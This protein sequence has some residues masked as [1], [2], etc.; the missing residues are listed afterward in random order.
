MPPPICHP[1][2][3]PIPS[4][5]AVFSAVPFGPRAGEYL[6]WYYYG[7][8]KKL[9]KDIYA[10]HNIHSIMCGVGLVTPGGIIGVNRP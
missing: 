3:G 5:L 7:G 2:N 8:G 4:A 1:A 9:M 10:K 6:A